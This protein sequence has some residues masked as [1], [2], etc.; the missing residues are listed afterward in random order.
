MLAGACGSSISPRHFVKPIRLLC[1]GVGMLRG[2][3]SS[4]DLTARQIRLNAGLPAPEVRI[5]FDHLVLAMGG[6]AGLLI[7][8]DGEGKLRG[9]LSLA[10]VFAGGTKR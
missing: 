2:T 9:V 8:A 5:G 3:I 7:V 4:I 10:D 1:R 6:G